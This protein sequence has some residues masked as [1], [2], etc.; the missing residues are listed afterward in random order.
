MSADIG[1]PPFAVVQSNDTCERIM[2]T[3]SI[4]LIYRKEV[5][6]Y[7]CMVLGVPR[8]AINTKTCVER[9]DHFNVHRSSG[10]TCEQKTPPFFSVL[11]GTRNGPK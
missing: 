1:H 5:G 10:E 3:W 7:M 11:L 6:F 4:K 9:G 8:R 2:S